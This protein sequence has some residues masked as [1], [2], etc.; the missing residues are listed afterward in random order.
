MASRC[1]ACSSVSEQKG[2]LLKGDDKRRDYVAL[3]I[4][5]TTPQL[6]EIIARFDSEIAMF[7]DFKP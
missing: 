1:A 4:Q 7:N 3:I 6:D 2:A 5:R